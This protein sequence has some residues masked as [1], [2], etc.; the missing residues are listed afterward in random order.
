ML[1]RNPSAKISQLGYNCSTSILPEI[2]SSHEV[3]SSTFTPP[4]RRSSNSSTGSVPRRSGMATIT[5]CT[6]FAPCARPTKCEATTLARQLPFHIAGPAHHF[7][8]QRRSARADPLTSR[9]RAFPG[10]QHVNPLAQKWLS[11][12]P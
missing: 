9:S 7:N 2:F 8:A 10:A 12:H 11:D 4:S 6:P 1:K 5:R 3:A